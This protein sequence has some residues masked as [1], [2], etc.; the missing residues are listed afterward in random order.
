MDYSIQS[1]NKIIQEIFPLFYLLINLV[2]NSIFLK[3]NKSLYLKLTWIVEKK[4]KSKDSNEEILL[5]IFNARGKNES[6]P[7]F[8]R[9]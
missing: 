1:L 4:S 2:Y 8:F 6:V 3:N 7:D 5:T 9:W